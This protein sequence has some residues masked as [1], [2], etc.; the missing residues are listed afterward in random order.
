MELT[1]VVDNPSYAR[2]P[3]SICYDVSPT[4][5]EVTLNFDLRFVESDL[6]IICK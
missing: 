4:S 5:T 2:K 6:I 1:Y 3:S